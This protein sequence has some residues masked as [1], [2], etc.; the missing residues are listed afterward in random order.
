MTTILVSVALH[1]ALGLTL[2]NHVC[3]HNWDCASGQCD[4]PKT[5]PVDGGWE[6]TC[7][8]PLGAPQ[9]CTVDGGN[10]CTYGSAYVS[11]NYVPGRGLET[12]C[13]IPGSGI[14]DAG[15]NPFA[16]YND[17]DC[18]NESGPGNTSLTECQGTFYYDA[19]PGVNTTNGEF[20]LPYSPGNWGQMVSSVCTVCSQPGAVTSGFTT[21]PSPCSA[22]CTNNCQGT[23]NVQ[24]GE[25]CCSAVGQQCLGDSDCCENDAGVQ[26]ESCFLTTSCNPDGG[27]YCS[28]LGKVGTCAYVDGQP[29]TTN[30]TCRSGVCGDAGLPHYICIGPC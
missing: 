21:S 14:F 9:A 8:E 6:L 22:C 3:T 29:C 11:C 15:P 5:N 7:C 27:T 20:F 28:N 30:E 25:T 26:T 10:C 23:E 17:S 13:G 1:L 18:I 19:G 4:N 24:N 16:C 12:G 2:D